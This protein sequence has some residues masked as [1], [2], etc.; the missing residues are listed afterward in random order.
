MRSLQDDS[1]ALQ[2]RIH[3]YTIQAETA[4]RRLVDV[5]AERIAIEKVVQWVTREMDGVEREAHELKAEI[6]AV[7]LGGG[8]VVGANGAGATVS[9]LP[10]SSSN[11]PP[12]ARPSDVLE[13]Q[14]LSNPSG[15][16]MDVHESGII[17]YSRAPAENPPPPALPRSEGICLDFNSGTCV[18][19]DASCVKAHV[20]GY[21]RSSSHAFKACTIKGGICL[22]FNRERRFIF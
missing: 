6:D 11:P 3:D 14:N 19:S 5:E 8:A 20:C 22:Y 9:P 7:S 17:R 16:A 15:S 2:D 13:N 10:L 4:R 1:N 12:S 18:F 21:C